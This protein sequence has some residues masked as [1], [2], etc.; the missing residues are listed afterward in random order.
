MN[1]AMKRYAEGIGKRKRMR[2]SEKKSCRSHAI[3]S[4]SRFLGQPFVQA[5]FIREYFKRS[6]Q[7]V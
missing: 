2:E 4:L 7:F 6:G 5:W 1:I 3:E